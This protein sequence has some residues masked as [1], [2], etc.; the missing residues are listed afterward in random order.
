MRICARCAEWMH[1][2]SHR[3]SHFL[4]NPCPEYMRVMGYDSDLLAFSMDCERWKQALRSTCTKG[5]RQLRRE[6]DVARRET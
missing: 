4:S 1:M 6:G 3:V 2:Y 5:K